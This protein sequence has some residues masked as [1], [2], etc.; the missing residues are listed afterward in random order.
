M[1]SV[2][3]GFTAEELRLV[4]VAVDLQVGLVKAISKRSKA[5]NTPASI[6]F[7]GRLV[8]LRD[9]L[10][11]ALQEMPPQEMENKNE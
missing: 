5:I 7:E 4:H 10:E 3:L 1:M 11:K 6:A 9:R 8:A 2:T